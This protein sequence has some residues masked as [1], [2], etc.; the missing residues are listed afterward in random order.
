MARQNTQSPTSSLHVPSAARNNAQSPVFSPINDS[1][2]METQMTQ[3]MMQQQLDNM[4][5]AL[6]NQKLGHDIGLAS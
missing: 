5:A 6:T 1:G 4:Q 2:R 3:A